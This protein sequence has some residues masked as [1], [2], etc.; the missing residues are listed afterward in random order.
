MFST[1]TKVLTSLTAT[2]A[3]AFV[4]FSFTEGGI[5]VAAV[6]I[7]LDSHFTKCI[8]ELPEGK[9]ELD[10]EF[11]KKR[12]DTDQ[13]KDI[14]LTATSKQQCGSAGC[15]HELCIVKDNRAELI[16]FG[17]AAETLIVKDTASNG[18]Y[19]IQLQGKSTTNL[20]WDGAR[21]VVLN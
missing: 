3:L 21:Y 9:R 12:I 5:N 15:A 4:T 11:I 18:M 1:R 6:I 2:L 7:G 13:K 19:D 16:T 17:Y 20:Q 10:Y 14:V 8:S